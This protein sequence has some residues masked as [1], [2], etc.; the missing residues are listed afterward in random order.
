MAEEVRYVRNVISEWQNQGPPWRDTVTWGDTAKRY[1]SRLF[2]RVRPDVYFTDWQE[3]A[4][5]E[6]LKVVVEC[7]IEVNEGS[8][9]LSDYVSMTNEL[10]TYLNSLAVDEQKTESVREEIEQEI[11]L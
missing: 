2:D 5:A 11:P 4:F 6:D 7:H 9:D 1:L 8:C 3:Q 10:A